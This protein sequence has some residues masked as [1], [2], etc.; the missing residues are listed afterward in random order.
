MNIEKI[1]AE[2]S[3]FANEIIRDV[4]HGRLTSKDILGFGIDGASVFIPRVPCAYINPTTNVCQSADNGVGGSSI[5]SL[6][7]CMIVL[8]TPLGIQTIVGKKSIR[9]DLKN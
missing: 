7:H 8:S 1:D 3:N 9:N 2:N 6:A 4:E 5:F